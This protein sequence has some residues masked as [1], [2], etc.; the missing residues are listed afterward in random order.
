[1]ARGKMQKTRKAMLS[2]VTQEAITFNALKTKEKR[3][4][5]EL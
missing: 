1:M 5:I 2:N 3:S 4:F